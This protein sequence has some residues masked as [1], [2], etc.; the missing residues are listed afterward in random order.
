[1]TLKFIRN[2]SVCSDTLLLVAEN[3]FFFVIKRIFSRFVYFYIEYIRYVTY[4]GWK[5]RTERNFL[6]HFLAVGGY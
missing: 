2:L 1:M 6:H 4:H 3:T 5:F